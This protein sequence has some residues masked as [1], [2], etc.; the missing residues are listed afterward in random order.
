MTYYEPGLVYENL[1]KMFGYRGLEPVEPE[2]AES[3]VSRAMSTHGII[4]LTARKIGGQENVL[5]VLLLGPNSE[6][7]TK[8]AEM[9]KALARFTRDHDAAVKSGSAA[10][11]Y[12]LMVV[13]PTFDPSVSEYYV[14]VM[15]AL[16]AFGYANPQ[17]YLEI[18]DYS[19]FLL[20][21]PKHCASVRHWIPPESEVAEY[22]K[23]YGKKTSD[24]PRIKAKD[25]Q[26]TWIGLRP[27]MVCAVDRVSETAGKAFVYKIC[28]H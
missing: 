23:K 10:A 19:V 24:F 8:T 4:I 11:D 21:I 9:N 25:A 26:A 17:I 20:E 15:K 14:H 18:C 6:Y 7:A 22:C 2:M 28:T 1:R 3:A 5:T 12:S 13:G 27:G 16:A